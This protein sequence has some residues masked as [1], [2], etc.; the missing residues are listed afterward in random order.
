MLS[1]DSYGS[2]IELKC[3]CRKCTIR[4]MQVTSRWVCV[5]VC[6]CMSERQ[7]LWVRELRV[8]VFECVCDLV[9]VSMSWWVYASWV[10]EC[11]FQSQY[12]WVRE[13]RLWVFECVCDLVSVSM[14]WWVYASEFLSVCQLVSVFVWGDECMRNEHQTPSVCLEY[15]I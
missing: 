3:V 5:W 13:L 2:S 8:W 10:F 11:M 7:Y 12:L 1:D 9:S 14:S 6:E 15:K 4:M